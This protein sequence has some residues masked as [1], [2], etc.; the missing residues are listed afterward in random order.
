MGCSPPGSSV[1]GILYHYGHLG[2][3]MPSLGNCKRPLND[4]LISLP[5]HHRNDPLFTRTPEGSYTEENE[6]SLSLLQCSTY[7]IKPYPTEGAY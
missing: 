5:D 6:N 4:L 2:S 1:H 3:L 7:K